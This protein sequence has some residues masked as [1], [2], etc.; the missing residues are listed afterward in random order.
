MYDMENL[1]LLIIESLELAVSTSLVHIIVKNI[2]IAKCHILSKLCPKGLFG[3]LDRFFV[4]AS[5]L[6]AVLA[7]KAV[8]LYC[9]HVSRFTGMTKT[10]CLRLND[11]FQN[12]YNIPVH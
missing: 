5:Y 4:C 11:C 2:F 10:G 8:I 7:N 12:C 3:I 6:F 1:L 9:Y